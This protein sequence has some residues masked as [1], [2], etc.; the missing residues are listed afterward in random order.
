MAVRSHP[1]K[2]SFSLPFTSPLCWDSVVKERRTR[3]CRICHGPS[4]EFL[5]PSELLPFFFT[6]MSWSLVLQAPIRPRV[7][8]LTGPQ[9]N[10]VSLSCRSYKLLGSPAGTDLHILKLNFFKRKKKR[11]LLTLLSTFFNFFFS[12]FPFGLFLWQL[13]DEHIWSDPPP[14]WLFL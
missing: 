9:E 11:V 1:W 3:T 7:S 14:F 13:F 12:L 6:C 5:P 2:R 10:Q 4:V 8:F